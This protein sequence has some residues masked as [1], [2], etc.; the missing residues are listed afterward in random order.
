MFWDHFETVFVKKIAY[1]AWNFENFRLRRSNRFNSAMV[2]A[3]AAI[4]EFN[5]KPY[6]P[7]HVSKYQFHNDMSVRYHWCFFEVL[8][9]HHV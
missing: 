3:S 4:R 6:E 7:H 9:P 5:Y 1:G 8:S 2:E